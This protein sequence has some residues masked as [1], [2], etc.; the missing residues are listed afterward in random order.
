MKNDHGLVY[1]EGGV[2]DEGICYSF[3]VD[4]KAA[5]KTY[6]E[7]R[8]AYDWFFNQIGFPFVTGGLLP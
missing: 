2:S 5:M 7:V 1:L 6:N 3:D 8:E 4:E